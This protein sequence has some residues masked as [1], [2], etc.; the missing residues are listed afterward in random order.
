M[1]TRLN[2]LFQ[3]TT[4]PTMPE[5]AAPRT[6][7]WSETY[8]LPGDVPSD[9]QKITGLLQR[10]AALLPAQGSIVG[11]RNAKYDIV[12]PRLIPRGSSTFKVTLRGNTQS[13]TDLLQVALMVSC[14][15]DGVPNTSR[16]CLRGIPDAQM[17]NG[18]Y[19]PD[20]GYLTLMTQ[21]LTYLS[22]QTFAFVAADLTQPALGVVKIEAGGIVTLTAAVAAAANVDK[23]IFRNVRNTEGEPI[24]GSYVIGSTANNTVTLLGYNGGLVAKPTGTARLDKKALIDISSAV[25]AYAVVRKVGRPSR[26]YRGRQSKRK[27][28]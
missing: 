1:I 15:G 20:Q 24:T 11:V 12:G 21:F 28:A 7:G 26:S 17:I 9:N 14:Q 10:R 16:I 27:A 3:A 8:T 23:L 13:A 4:S 2:F 25:P 5:F 19:Q 18:E 6:G 22:T